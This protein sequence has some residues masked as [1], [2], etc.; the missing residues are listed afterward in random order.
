MEKNTRVKARVKA[1]ALREIIE[2]KERV[3]CMGH[4]ITDIDTFGAAVGIYRVTRQ[5]DK[6]CHIVINNVTQSIKPFM[7]AYSKEADFDPDMFVTSAEALQ[8]AD[9]DSSVMV[10]VDTKQAVH[11]RVP[12]AFEEDQDH[13]GTGSPQSRDGDHRECHALIYRALCIQCL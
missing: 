3:F 10:V 12:G 2:Q 11:N 13:R 6:K 9:S 1:Q 8:L 4:Q 5:L 7:D